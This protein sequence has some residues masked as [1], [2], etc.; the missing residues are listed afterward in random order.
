MFEALR[1]IQTVTMPVNW[2]FRRTRRVGASVTC[3]VVA[4]WRSAYG[5]GRRSGRA[6]LTETLPLRFRCASRGRRCGWGGRRRR[7][8]RSAF[9][10]SASR[11]CGAVPRGDPA[12]SHPLS[13]PPDVGIVAQ[14]R[15]RGDG[16]RC[17]RLVRQVSGCRRLRRS[18][19]VRDG[20]ADTRHNDLVVVDV[21]VPRHLDGHLVWAARGHLCRHAL[22]SGVRRRRERDERGGSRGT[23]QRDPRVAGVRDD[24][25]AHRRAPAAPAPGERQT[26]RETA[27]RAGRPAPSH[28]AGASRHR[29]L[30]GHDGRHESRGGQTSQGS[31][32][33]A[34]R[35]PRVHRADRARRN[36]RS[37][38]Y[39]RAFARHG[40]P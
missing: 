30:F 14:C 19:R 16:V 32:P 15:R 7:R 36:G 18:R 2:L 6:Y 8:R 3:T 39:A 27:G 12:C 13:G 17:G 11:F 4:L 37:E 35:G 23:R 26:R 33:P 31:G 22:V 40:Q 29:R 38:A 9:A 10:R 24:F 21:H 20:L 5:T 25:R 1:G 28:R 34:C